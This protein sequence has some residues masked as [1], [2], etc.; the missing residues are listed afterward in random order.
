MIGTARAYVFGDGTLIALLIAKGVGNSPELQ[1]LLA[2]L[3]P[4]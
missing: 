4:Q 3:S 2:S 1:Q